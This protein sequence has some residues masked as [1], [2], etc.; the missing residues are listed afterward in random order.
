M[1]ALGTQCRGPVPRGGMLCPYH[2][3]HGPGPP[4]PKIMAKSTSMA[5]GRGS[6][7]LQAT[8]ACTM[9]INCRD[10]IA[11]RA[12]LCSVHGAGAALFLLLSSV[13]SAGAA[14]VRVAC[15]RDVPSTAHG[16]ESVVVDPAV[17]EAE[18]IG[19]KS[20]RAHVAK[21]KDHG[22]EHQHLPRRVS[23]LWGGREGLSA[24]AC[25]GVRRARKGGGRCGV[26]VV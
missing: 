13:H 12:L 1:Q 19:L 8:C 15:G 7:A 10:G 6:S 20:A 21:A 26:W 11:V 5:R 23:N 17:L 4:R 25:L 16:A 14:R 3:G 9:A 24:S 2:R 22:E 18:I